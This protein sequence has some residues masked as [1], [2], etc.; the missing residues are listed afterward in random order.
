MLMERILGAFT[1]KKEV[2]ADV[3]HDTSFTNTAWAIVAAVAFAIQIP[4]LFS[5]D[6]IGGWLFGAVVSVAFTV[7]GFAVGAYVIAWVGKSMFQAEVSFEE[8]VRTLGLAY[9]WNIAGIFGSFFFPLLCIGWILGLASWFVAAREA[10]DLESGQ[11]IITVIIGWVVVFV[12]T[13]AAGFVLGLLGL[14]ASVL[15]GVLAQ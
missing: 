6:S 2:Y 5:T 10:L 11:T 4:A 3:E 1:F 15:S 8:M 9:V 14:G 7:F 12:I 13:L